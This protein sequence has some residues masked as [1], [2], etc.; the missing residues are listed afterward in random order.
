MA[1]KKNRP[2]AADCLLALILLLLAAGCVS[3][4]TD[5]KPAS[6][7]PLDTAKITAVQARLQQV[8]ELA[9]NP[10]KVTVVNQE[11]T[12]EGA[13]ESEE[14]SKMAEEQALKV[15]GITKVNNKIQVVK[16]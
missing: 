14:Y 9:G 3:P 1:V 15:E 11:C 7:Q 6:I 13:V 10:I 5:T 12:L 8:R 16:K 2:L 4:K